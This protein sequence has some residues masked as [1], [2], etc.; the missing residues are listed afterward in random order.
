M[1]SLNDMAAPDSPRREADSF[2]NLLALVTDPNAVKARLKE[3]IDAQTAAHDFIEAAKTERL[4]LD[5]ARKEQARILKG[6]RAEHDR[7]LAEAKAKS[8]RDCGMAMEEVRALRASAEQALAKAQRDASDAAAN[9]KD[10][11]RRVDQIKSAV[12]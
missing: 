7:S 12:I 4:A 10:L 5:K 1:L 11:R 8:D 6:E 3:I 9:L 2:F